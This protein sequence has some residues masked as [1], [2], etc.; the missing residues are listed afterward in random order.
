MH[1]LIES[2]V[3]SVKVGVIVL[4]S[5]QRVVLWNRWM[6]RTA[7]IDAAAMLGCTFAD[8]FPDMVNGRTHAAIREALE[9]NF[10][11]LISQTLN[12]APF[13][14]YAGLAMDIAAP[15]MQQGVQVIPLDVPGE[16][17]FCL[18]QITDVSTAVQR[19]K[20]LREQSVALKNL[21]VTDRLTGIPNRRRF[22]EYLEQ[23]FARA[24][25][26]V[27][28]LSL[29]MIDIDFFKPYNDHYGPLQ[30]DRCL[31]EVAQVLAAVV[32]RPTDLVA[33]YGGEEFVAIMPDT[34]PDGA[35]KLAEAMRAAIEA[36]MIEHRHSASAQVVTVSIG[37]A[38]QVPAQETASAQ[39]VH[40]A[41]VALYAAKHAG[42]NRV[43]AGHSA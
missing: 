20:Q 29:C 3:Q 41:D 38:T 1:V 26:A 32:K 25:R 19:E 7:R 33:R 6:E 4:D 16:S 37:V 39:L 2:V 17:R 35:L 36:L 21:T 18:I 28:P 30:G 24:R 34:N 27:A 8:A 22:D 31:S 9:N 43:L 13:P 14:L 5:Q 10:P 42:R 40:A 15:R 12:K 11:S 23:E